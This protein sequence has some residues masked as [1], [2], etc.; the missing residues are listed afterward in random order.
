MNFDANAIAHKLNTLLRSPVHSLLTLLMWTAFIM[1]VIIA[2]VTIFR[3]MNTQPVFPYIKT[4]S[5]GLELLYAVA[6]VAMVCPIGW[7]LMKLIEAMSAQ[8]K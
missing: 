8:R 1:C 5:T 4:T 6:T 7:L 3:Q 2:W